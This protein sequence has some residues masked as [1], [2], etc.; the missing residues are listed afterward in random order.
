[1]SGEGQVTRLDLQTTSKMNPI[2]QEYLRN[3]RR[4]L[5]VAESVK[6]NPSVLKYQL[7]SAESYWVMFLKS[8]RHGRFKDQ[9]ERFRTFLK[10]QDIKGALNFLSV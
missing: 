2:A 4:A 5:K 6:F 9:V 8:T 10:A 1:M 7:A 3:A